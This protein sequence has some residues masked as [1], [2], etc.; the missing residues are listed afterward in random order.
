LPLGSFNQPSANFT[1][2]FRHWVSA[3]PLKAEFNLVFAEGE[4]KNV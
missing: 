1:L 3:L 4:I 2:Y